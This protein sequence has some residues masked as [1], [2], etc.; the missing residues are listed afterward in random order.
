MPDSEKKILFLVGCPR[1]GTTLVQEILNRHPA[2]ALAPELFYIRHFVETTPTLQ[3][4]ESRLRLGKKII[5][6][7]WFDRLEIE[8]EEFLHWMETRGTTH[9]LIYRELLRRYGAQKDATWIGDKTP[10]NVL[11]IPRL[12]TY[13]PDAV[14][15]HILRDPRA[16]VRSW[17]TVPWTT[18]TIWG[19]AKIWRKYIRAWDRFR[20]YTEGR[21]LTIRYEDVIGNPETTVQSICQFLNLPYDEA[22]LN[23]SGRESSFVPEAEPWK[24]NAAAGID[25]DL[26]DRWQQELT[27]TEIA[28]IEWICGSDM[29]KW[30]YPLRTKWWHRIRHL[31]VSVWFPYVTFLRRK[32]SK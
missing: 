17:K 6:Q 5:A 29:V 8:K 19:D 12:L 15:L 20:S 26:R 10:N 3:D 22:L 14:F 27:S 1:S 4:S 2:I 25:P 11:Y 13:F 24:K 16:V 18:G 30:G 21:G 7:D 32:L 23:P 31:S 9:A 28:G